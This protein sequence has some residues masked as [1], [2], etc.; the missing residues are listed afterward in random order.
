MTQLSH[1][2]KSN[3]FPKYKTYSCAS[4]LFQLLGILVVPFGQWGIYQF[5]A[6]I[7]QIRGVNFYLHICVQVRKSQVPHLITILNEL[8]FLIC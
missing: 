2:N 7:T 6:T 4:V 1:F 3:H 5:D 8:E